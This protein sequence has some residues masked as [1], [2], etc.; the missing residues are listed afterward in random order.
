MCKQRHQ[1]G[2]RVYR[3]Q[4]CVIRRIDGQTITEHHAPRWNG[5]GEIVWCD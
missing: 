4:R 1:V 2:A 5:H 3:C